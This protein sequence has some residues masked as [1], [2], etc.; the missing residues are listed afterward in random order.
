MVFIISSKKNQRILH[1]KEIKTRTT[2]HEGEFIKGDKGKSYQQKYSRKYLGKDLSIPT[3][4][5]RPD[6]QKE[7]AKA[8]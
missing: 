7:L 5:N 1:W 3:D 8:K 4:F 2:T 6:Y